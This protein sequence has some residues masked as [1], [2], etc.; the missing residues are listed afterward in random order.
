MG[1]LKTLRELRGVYR[2]WPSIALRLG[3]H[4]GSPSRVVLRDGTELGPPGELSS[5]YSLAEE[6]RL[7]WTVEGGAEGRVRLGPSPEVQ[8][9]ARWSEG[10]DV[11]NA[12]EVFS[13]RVYAQD[14]RGKVVL[15][16]GAGDG[17]SALFFAAEGAAKVVAL[18]PNP[19]S[20]VLAERNARASRFGDRISVIRAAAGVHNGSAELRF[21]RSVPNAASL[22]PVAPAERRWVFDR[23]ISVPV[24]SLED[25][26]RE[27]GSE[28]LGLLKLDVQGMEYDLVE[29]V[30]DDGW[31]RVES[32]ILEFTNGPQRL[33][34]RLESVGFRVTASAGERGYLRASRVP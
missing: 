10:F 28:P 29:G 5:L 21:P 24:R 16:L 31:G 17:D 1:R 22:K 27:S 8:F 4:G 12:G 26:V 15:D 33:R 13:D 30:S 18:E 32:V 25:L 6:R 14:V 20:F 9:E 3:L 23:S 34:E 11:V 19:E 7:G 2:N